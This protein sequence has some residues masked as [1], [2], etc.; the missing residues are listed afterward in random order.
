MNIDK[1]LNDF[2]KIFIEDSPSGDNDDDSISKHGIGYCPQSEVNVVKPDA[3]NI[4]ECHCRERE[5]YRDVYNKA[6]SY[7]KQ[8]LDNPS[9][10]VWAMYCYDIAGEIDHIPLRLRG[11]YFTYKEV[12]QVAENLYKSMIC[13]NRE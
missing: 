10:M 6:L 5:R 13:N 12:E 3:I 9:R 7:H 1:F 11:R 8:G 2:N 4:L